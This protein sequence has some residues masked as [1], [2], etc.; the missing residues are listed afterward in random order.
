MSASEAILYYG[1]KRFRTGIGVT[2]PSQLRYIYY[3]A[4][5]YKKL[6]AKP[7]CKILDKIVIRTTPRIGSEGCRPFIEVLVGEDFQTCLYTNKNAPLLKRYKNMG[8]KE[9]KMSKIK[10][11]AENNPLL[12]GDV[13]IRIKH[14]GRWS[15]A[16]GSSECG[17]LLCCR[18][19]KKLADL[20][21]FVQHSIQQGQVI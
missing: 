12:F 21:L 7:V 20:P 17:V 11:S 2:Q 16:C 3:Y 15:C 9:D 1:Y 6:V 8:E 19:V 4:Q 10:I 13:H 14:K 18:E 5:L